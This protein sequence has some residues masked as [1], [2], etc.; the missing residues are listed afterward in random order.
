MSEQF[1]TG[2]LLVAMPAVADPRFQKSVIF[3]T[4]HDADGAMGIVIN[5]ILPNMTLGDLFEQTGVK[6]DDSKKNIPVMMGGPVE[7][8]RG[9]L[10][11]TPDYSSAETIIVND[12]FRVSA[13]IEALQS[14]AEHDVPKDVVFALGYAGWGPNQLEEEVL[15][16]A[17]LIVDADYELI[18]N[19]RAD[20]KWERAMSR[21]GIDPARLSG[22]AGHA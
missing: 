11:H 17:W 13:T 6:T 18:F 7:I 2:K 14:F 19:T 9:F 3:V 10:V 21:H 5:Q 1:L 20:D 8:S 22:D 12:H 4:S 15:E 16:N